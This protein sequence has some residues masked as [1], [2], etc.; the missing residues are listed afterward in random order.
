A[1]GANPVFDLAS[2][3]NNE[4]GNEE[5]FALLTP[6]L[7]AGDGGEASA[8]GAQFQYF[9]GSQWVVETF[10]GDAIE[11]PMEYLHTLQFKAAP[12]FSGM[13]EI[14]VQAKT[15]DYDED[16]PGDQGRADVQISGNATLTNI[17]IAP[18]ADSVTATV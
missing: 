18:K 15:V 12:H 10:G 1:D 16:H 17:L 4:D 7:I 2:G 9:D 6:H 5:T 11:V 8:I 3:W 13:F 14:G